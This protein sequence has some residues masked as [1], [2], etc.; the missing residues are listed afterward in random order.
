[1]FTKNKILKYF[2]TDDSFFSMS[3]A[4][5]VKNKDEMLANVKIFFD[6]EKIAHLEMT[7]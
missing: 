3:S 6:A 5:A 7:I 4:Y 1:V 2:Q